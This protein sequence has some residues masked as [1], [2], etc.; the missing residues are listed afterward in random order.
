MNKVKVKK[1]LIYPKWWPSFLRYACVGGIVFFIDVGTFQLLILA[2]LYRP[3]ATTIA[4]AIA[5]TSHFTLN[6]FFNFKNFDR[7]TWRQLRTYLVVV[8]FCWAITVIV[9]ET[10]VSWLGI[11]PLI[12]KLMAIAINIPTGF[13][14]NRYFTFGVGIRATLRR[15]QQRWIDR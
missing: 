9:I 7:S 12:A 13:L 5:V 6:K 11:V 15:W 3:L 14:A 2:Q 4:Y 1:K 8:F 10:S